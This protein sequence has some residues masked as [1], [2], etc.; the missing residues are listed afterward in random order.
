MKRIKFTLS[1][2]IYKET[3]DTI[4]KANKD[5]REITHQNI[6]LEPIRQK[7]RSKHRLAQ[8]KLIRKHAASLYQ[9][10]ITDKVWKCSCRML[11]M[12]SLRLEPRPDALVAVN[13]DTV[14]RV[15]FRI[16]LST[17]QG[18]E[19]PWVASQWQEVEIEPSLDQIVASTTSVG[20][21]S[22]SRVVRFGPDLISTTTMDPLQETT[23]H[24]GYDCESIADMCS[25]LC[26]KH[27][28][29]KAIGFLVDEKDNKH[30]HYLYRANTAIGPEPR[31]KSLDDLLSCSGHGSHSAPLSRN[32]RLRIA[33][34]LASSVL[35]LDGTPWLKPQWSSKEIFF[36]EKN[37]RASDP[38][39]TYPYMSWRLCK[40]DT[41]VL[42]SF[43]SCFRGTYVV[44]SEVLFALGVTLIELCF[45]KT[46]ADMHVPED[47][48]P[49]E[50]TTEM[51]TALRLC[52]SV[53]SEMG[54]SYGDAVRRCLYQP[55]DVRDLSLDNEELQ[56]KVF[57]DIV[58]PLNDDWL[59]FNGKLVV[60]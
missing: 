2:N 53:Y 13:A 46:L 52:S 48:D 41:N 5:L 20:P 12:A 57:D 22:S 18:E 38:N 28:P 8:L 25:T 24:Y 44:R 34:T 27:G 50:A 1:K 30:K 31:S 59:I 9:V 14:P 26:A 42:S 35:Q 10:L 29:T 43:D 7:R 37:N 55:F 4:D 40:T 3:L 6:Y 17:R 11:H 36:H 60:R 16:L 32:D 54:T 15:R 56:Q 49:E 58:T 51:K 19:S 39:Y 33:V 23:I 45:G 21:E 47:G